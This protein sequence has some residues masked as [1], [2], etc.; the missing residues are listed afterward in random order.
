MDI[1]KI[2]YIP[3]TISCLKNYHLKN[4]QKV[5]FQ[6]SSNI[7]V[8]IETK[9]RHKI[10]LACVQLFKLVSLLRMLYKLMSTHLRLLVI[11]FHKL[12][13]FATLVAMDTE[14]RNILTFFILSF[15]TQGISVY[16]LC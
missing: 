12:R 13:Q 2:K 4:G 7:H 1:P 9:M 10:K 16:S 3:L 5:Q 15:K 8:A 6:A 11:L 14:C